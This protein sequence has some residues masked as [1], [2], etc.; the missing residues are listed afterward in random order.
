MSAWLERCLPSKI[1]LC[2]LAVCN[3]CMPRNICRGTATVP[4]CT[5]HQ[6]EEILRL[7]CKMLPVKSWQDLAR[8]SCPTDSSGA[9]HPVCLLQTQLLGWCTSSPLGVGLPAL[10]M[11]EQQS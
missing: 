5:L 7:R 2:T 1:H 9:E 4:R 6:G 11:P 8:S 3:S 10:H